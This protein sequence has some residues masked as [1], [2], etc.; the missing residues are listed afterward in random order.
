MLLF[1]ASYCEPY[2]PQM[3]TLARIQEEHGT[4]NIEVVVVAVNPR[5]TPTT[6][7]D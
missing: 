5:E 2:K 7:G 1:R 3:G 6:C 4:N